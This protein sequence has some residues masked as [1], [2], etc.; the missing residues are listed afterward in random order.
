MRTYP[1]EIMIFNVTLG[2][3]PFFGRGRAHVTPGRNCSHPQSVSGHKEGVVGTSVQLQTRRSLPVAPLALRIAS[4]GSWLGK[5]GA[6][7]H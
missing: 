2:A 4:R 7:P 1:T 3:V 5:R 6:V